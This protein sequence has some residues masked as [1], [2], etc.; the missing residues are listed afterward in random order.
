MLNIFY[1]R[2]NGTNRHILTWLG[3]HSCCLWYQ[4]NNKLCCYSLIVKKPSK[5]RN[6][7]L[8][9][10]ERLWF[11]LRV[12][13]TQKLVYATV[14]RGWYQVNVVYKGRVFLFYNTATHV[15]S[16]WRNTEICNNWILY[17]FSV[18]VMVHIYSRISEDSWN[19]YRCVGMKII[20]L[21]S[22]CEC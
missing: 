20:S 6:S 5:V 18:L 19:I 14:N 22:V 16:L 17:C 21:G 12:W 8:I 2:N 10:Q 13:C 9:L 4:V 1:V 3:T 15:Y 11:G 7:S